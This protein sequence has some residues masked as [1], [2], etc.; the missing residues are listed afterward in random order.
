MVRSE[1]DK[2]VDENTDI[3]VKPQGVSSVRGTAFLPLSPLIQPCTC[4]LIRY[5]ID[6]DIDLLSW[7]DG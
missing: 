4:I 7:T 1:H 6:F 2:H 3:I 5:D